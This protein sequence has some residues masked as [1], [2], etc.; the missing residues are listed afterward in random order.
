MGTAFPT[1]NGAPLGE[2]AHLHDACFS[3]GFK[4]HQPQLRR[5]ALRHANASKPQDTRAQLTRSICSFSNQFDGSRW[6]QPNGSNSLLFLAAGSAIGSWGGTG[7]GKLACL[8]AGPHASPAGLPTDPKGRLR[9]AV[10]QRGPEG[11]F[12]WPQR[13]GGPALRR[14]PGGATGSGG[15]HRCR[16][17]GPLSA[18]SDVA[19]STASET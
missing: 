5:P 15:K 4:Q 17:G 11:P 18:V 13:S 1:R 19:V 9:G 10:L 6:W 16:F 12:L 14:K 2:V 8:P 3:C 7:H